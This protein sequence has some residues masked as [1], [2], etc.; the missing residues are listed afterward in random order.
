VEEPAIEHG[1]ELLT[2]INEA[3]DICPMSQT[4]VPAA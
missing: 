1:A 3:K 4:G 2:Q